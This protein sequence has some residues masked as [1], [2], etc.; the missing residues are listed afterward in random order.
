MTKVYFTHDW[1]QLVFLAKMNYCT[2]GSLY[3]VLTWSEFRPDMHQ[4]F[5]IHS[6]MPNMNNMQLFVC[7]MSQQYN[8]YDKIGISTLFWHRVKEYLMCAKPL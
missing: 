4:D 7:E 8:S 5:M 2:S 6:H 1:G 3:P